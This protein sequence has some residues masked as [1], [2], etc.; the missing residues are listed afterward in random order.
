[1]A[2]IGYV[3]PAILVRI[4]VVQE[5]ITKIA[6]SELSNYLGVPVKIGSVD[7]EWLNHLVLE[8]VNLPDRDGKV[9]LR[10]H[11][12][13]A[14]FELLPL[15]HN[16]LVFTTVRLFGVT[17]NLRKASADKPLNLQFVL[18][19]FAS[20][21]KNK[22]K[23]HIDLRL[24]SVLIRR[25]IFTYNIEDQQETPGKFN[26]KH[27][28]LRNLSAKISLKA[29]TKDSLNASIRKMSF[30]ESSGFSLKRLDL[31][32]VGNKDSAIIDNFEIR[33]PSTDLVLARSKVDLRGI[34]DMKTLLERAPLHLA[35]TSSQI[36]LKDFSPFVPALHNFTDS[37]E[38]IAEAT[39]S[40]NNL[41][42][43]Q[44]SLKYS[45]KMLFVGNVILKDLTHPK[46]LYLN[47]EVRKMYLTTEGIEGFANNFSDKPVSL[48]D[49][50]IRIGTINFTGEISGFVDNLAAVGK[51]S[52]NVGSIET[53]VHFGK[54]KSKGIATYVKG[55]IQ[56]NGFHLGELMAD[57]KK[58]GDVT[59]DIKIDAKRP[60]K[61]D[62]AGKVMAN[63]NKFD[64]Q[65]HR[66]DKILLDGA[67]TPHSFDG[68]LRIN[69]PDGSLDAHGFFRR[70]GRNSIYNVTADVAHLHP[71][72]L[73]LTD[74]YEEPEISCRIN[75][76]FVGNHIDNIQGKILV[77]DLQFKTRPSSFHLDSLKV[78]ASGQSK[79][80]KL[81]IAS[82]VL[83]GEV[84]G[85]YSFST[86]IP[87]LLQTFKGYVP[88]LVKAA[89]GKRSSKAEE[90]NFE[91]M[92][93][94]ERCEDICR[95]LKLPFTIETTSRLVAFYNNRF[96]RF[97]MEAWLPK[98]M[99]GSSR[100]EACHI[101][102]E[103]PS[104]EVDIQL[105]ATNYN[106]KGLENYLDLK[107]SAKD[108]LLN[109]VINW[110]NNKPNQYKATLSASTK[111]AEETDEL[112][113]TALTTH[114]G[115]N[116]STLTVKD[117]TWNISPSEVSIRNGR[118]HVQHFQVVRGDQHL[119]L[120]G[121]V[122]KDPTDTLKVDMHQVE[123][124]YIFDVLNIEVLQFGGEATGKFYLSDVYKS[125]MLN[126]DLE[127]KNF[128]FNKVVLGRLNMFSEWDNEQKGISMMGTIYKND[129]TWTD[130][131]GTVYPV[132]PNSGLSLYFDANDLN[133]AFIH[134]F[135]D[136]VVKNL[137]GRGFG[138]VHLYGPFSQLNVVGDVMIRDGGFGIDFLNTY[139]SIDD[140]I[141]LSPNSINFRNVTVRDKFGNQGRVTFNVNHEHFHNFN[142]KADIT[143]DRM[144]VYNATAKQHPLLYGTA[145]GSGKATIQGNGD[146]INFDINMQSEPNTVVG[147]NFMENSA[148]DD[149]NFIKF[150]DKNKQLAASKDSANANDGKKDDDGGTEF[151]MNIQLDVTPD[152]EIQLVMDPTAG[153]MIKGNASGNLQIQY[154]TKSDLRIYGGLN[155]TEGKYNFSMQ[156]II[157]RD[158]TLREGST[159]TFNGDPYSA[160]LNVN[161]IYR[162]TANL[163]DLDEG[164]LVESSRTNVPVNCVLNINGVM[165]SPEISFD[166]ELPGSNEELERQVKSLVNTEDMMTR[167]I[168][169]LLVL[170]KFYTPDYANGYRGSEFS[171]VASSAIS[172]QLSGLLNSLTDKVQIGANIRASQDGF[173]NDTEMEMLLSSQLLNNRLLFNGNFGYKNNVNLNQN[174][175]VGEFDLEYK[176]TK[177]GDIRLKA[178][179]HAND[180]YQYL[181]QSLTTQGVGIIFKKDF[182]NVSD[183]FRRTR[184]LLPPLRMDTTRTELK[185]DSTAKKK[186]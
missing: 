104:D 51:M 126:T 25:G 91:M 156:Q 1:M 186:Q 84:T 172:Q 165:R 44:L 129:S 100:F 49:A 123:L 178:Y 34:H 173:T 167:Q 89:N 62:F 117:T 160:N 169:Y 71:D 108:N 60:E 136:G 66:Y 119:Y 174:V 114:I 135:V 45:D 155:I 48:P 140:S 2:W 121:F 43:R 122:S 13:T 38:L 88:A 181:K 10:A 5:R 142:F 30:D 6:S 183:I 103:N 90:N 39:G 131:N 152:A 4:P 8:N 184:V 175:F 161:A 138:N 81:T 98:F 162:V 101:Q 139:Y 79:S 53:D 74:K 40:V 24:N 76:N 33:L 147:L 113:K 21:D 137:Q 41:D 149:Y 73:H 163:G 55:H 110:A 118:I 82:D 11:Q 69:D 83:N 17:V 97:R 112:G 146:V 72:K 56:S 9:L 102:C 63:V 37:L 7:I 29:F 46:N 15:F 105:R 28:R 35:I 23:N 52:S 67:F 116:P 75:S 99:L 151:R 171:A 58:F 36:C 127:V 132:G 143:A 180:M 141:H 16:K 57:H 32:I 96:N 130:V 47:G 20:K 158:F 80:R 115:L 78:E 125:M 179:N 61:G 87:C 150:I 19:A 144:L 120:N 12:L 31:E 54:D 134:P 27:I 77:E 22:K 164:L 18:D 128:S 106:D 92:M 124:S 154:G 93:T 42:L 168:I 182:T 177:T 3:M 109:S 157:H 59:L 95:T 185:S 86:L 176:L 133:I 65:G 64:Y 111:F 50:L 148:A 94:V 85:A 107:A 153:D 170:N 68:A 159:V 166:L 26:S 14:G 70:E 145:F